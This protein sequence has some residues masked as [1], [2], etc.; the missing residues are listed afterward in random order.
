MQDR[1]LGYF[2]RCA[3]FYSNSIKYRESNEWPDPL[4][5]F[6]KTAMPLMVLQP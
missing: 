3:Y 5:L 2:V 4:L 6:S 1:L